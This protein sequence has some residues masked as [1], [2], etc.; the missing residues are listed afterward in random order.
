M[1]TETLALAEVD[2]H[3]DVFDSMS[4]RE[5]MLHVARKID[6]FEKLVGELTQAVDSNPMAK[7]FLGK[8]GGKVGGLFG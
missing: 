2:P 5:L 3:T 1:D 4:D 8:M 6:A 7:M